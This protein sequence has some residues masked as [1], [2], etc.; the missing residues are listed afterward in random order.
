MAYLRIPSDEGDRVGS[1]V[2]MA[3]TDGLEVRRNWDALGMRASCSN[4]I[5][6]TDCFVSEMFVFPG[7][8]GLRDAR[9]GG[10]GAS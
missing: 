8:P 3:G 6:F 4:E 10:A 2:V 5:V 1:A 7:P 9:P